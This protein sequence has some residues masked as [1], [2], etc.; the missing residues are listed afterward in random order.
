MAQPQGEIT[1]PTN[2]RGPPLPKGREDVADRGTA[3]ALRTN[4][5]AKAGDTQMPGSSKSA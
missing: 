4:E 3:T 1:Q 5:L 2:G